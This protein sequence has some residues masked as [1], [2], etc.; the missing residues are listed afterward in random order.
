MKKYRLKVGMFR[1]PSR[2]IHRQTCN[3]KYANLFSLT[4]C[5]IRSATVFW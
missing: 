3:R 4:N 1:A 2:I 5:D